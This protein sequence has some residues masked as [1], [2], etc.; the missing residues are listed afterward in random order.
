MYSPQLCSWGIWG[1]PVDSKT[2]LTASVC[3]FACVCA[4]FCAVLSLCDP[5]DGSPPGSSVHGILQAR[6][7]QWVAISSPRGS[8]RWTWVSC[9]AGTF[10]TIRA[11]RG[12]PFLETNTMNCLISLQNLYFTHPSCYVHKNGICKT[13]YSVFSEDILAVIL[14]FHIEILCIIL[15]TYAPSCY[16]DSANRIHAANLFIDFEIAIIDVFY[17][18]WVANLCSALRDPVNCSLPGFPVLHYLLEYAQIYVN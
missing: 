12:S 6:I 3:V 1:S 2:K 14:C 9:L 11:S 15:Y 8:Y 10:L 7:Q 13:K 17:C 5:M 16:M 18:C 4:H